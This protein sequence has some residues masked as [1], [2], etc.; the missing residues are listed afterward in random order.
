MHLQIHK[1]QLANRVLSVGDA[2]RA[3]RLADA[4]MPGY[5]VH[6]SSRGFS[7][8]TGLYKGTPV[9]IVAT[10]MV[11]QGLGCG[12]RRRP[13]APSGRARPCVPGRAVGSPAPRLPA[14][15]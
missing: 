7:T 11:R 9:S 14:P 10:G 15:R 13:S 12:A 4:L 6:G 2:G 8:Y 1:G 3:K 5:A